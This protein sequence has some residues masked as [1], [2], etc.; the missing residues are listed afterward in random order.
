M[1]S[2]AD[3]AN[4]FPAKIA[5]ADMAPASAI[6]FRDTDETT[7]EIDD[8]TD[9]AVDPSC[10]IAAVGAE[11]SFAAPPTEDSPPPVTAGDAIAL[12]ENSPDSARIGAPR[13]LD[14]LPATAAAALIGAP[15]T[16]ASPPT[17]IVFALR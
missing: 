10:E 9:V 14:T 3:A 5:G 11:S 12:R 16:V 15:N 6:N 4:D 13:I 17:K 2:F 1:I 8:I 7:L